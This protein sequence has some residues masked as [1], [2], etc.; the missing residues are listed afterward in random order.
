MDID[1]LHNV[2]YWITITSA[3]TK[4]ETKWKYA[5]RRAIV[6]NHPIW[7]NIINPM[8]NYITLASEDVPEWVVVIYR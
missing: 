4:I 5:P 1:H 7:T 3:K 2:E 6:F 8:T